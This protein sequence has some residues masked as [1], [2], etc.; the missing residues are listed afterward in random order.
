MAL[1]QDTPVILLDEPTTYLDI[2]HQMQLM[3]Q[4][5]LLAQRGKTILMILHDLPCA[6]RTADNLVLLN[7]GSIT[8]EGTPEQLYA[9]GV[10]DCVFGVGLGRVETE[11]GWHYY[12]CKDNFM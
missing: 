6:F 7:Q 9:S 12:Y 2:Q 8:K 4:V 3:Q 5:K 1:A 11:T 10:V